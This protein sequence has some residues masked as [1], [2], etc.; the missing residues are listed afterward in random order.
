MIPTAL[1]SDHQQLLATMHLPC[2]AFAK[3]D[4]TG[5]SQWLSASHIFRYQR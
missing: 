2:T 1:Y 4:T 3:C 5:L